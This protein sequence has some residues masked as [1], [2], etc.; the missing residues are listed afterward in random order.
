M[1]ARELIGEIADGDENLLG[2]YQK[3]LTRFDLFSPINATKLREQVATHM[4]ERGE[5]SLT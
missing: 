1:T 2:K 5:Y 3:A 4:V